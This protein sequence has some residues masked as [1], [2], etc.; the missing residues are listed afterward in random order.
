L[1]TNNKGFLMIFKNIQLE[2]INNFYSI[3]AIKYIYKNLLLIQV[4]LF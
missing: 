4:K 3:K 1:I 2:I